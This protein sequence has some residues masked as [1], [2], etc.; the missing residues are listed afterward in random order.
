[1]ELA[2]RRKSSSGAREREIGTKGGFQVKVVLE[3]SI[4]GCWSCA[5]K[6][7]SWE[8]ERVGGTDLELLEHLRARVG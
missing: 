1:M 2:S 6:G 8:G 3:K 7:V 4:S 5:T